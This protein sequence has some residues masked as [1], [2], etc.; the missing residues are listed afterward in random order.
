MRF[1]PVSI[2]INSPPE[3]AAAAAG[4]GPGTPV[5]LAGGAGVL[6]ASWGPAPVNAPA[7]LWEFGGAILAEDGSPLL[8]EDNLYG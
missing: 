7:W 5:R 8:L 6:A 1:P 2:Q 4:V 3:A